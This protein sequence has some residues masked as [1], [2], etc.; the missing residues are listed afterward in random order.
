VGPNSPNGSPGRLKDWRSWHFLL[1]M[2]RAGLSGCSYGKR[3]ER[4]RIISL[5]LN[6]AGD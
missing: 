3:R 1:K 4:K 6:V 2:P 5:K